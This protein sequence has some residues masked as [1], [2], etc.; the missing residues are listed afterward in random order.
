MLCILKGIG[1]NFGDSIGHFINGAVSRYGKIN[2]L[3]LLR[4]WNLDTFNPD[5]VVFLVNQ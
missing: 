5:I 1:G 4:L 3:V 2:L